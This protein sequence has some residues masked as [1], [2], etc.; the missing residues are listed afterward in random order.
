MG[1][2]GRICLYPEK[3]LAVKEVEDPGQKGDNQ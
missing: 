2:I 1:E 3:S